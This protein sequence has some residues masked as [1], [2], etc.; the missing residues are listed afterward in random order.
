MNNYPHPAISREDWPF[1]AISMDASVKISIEDRVSVA[2][3]ILATL[4][5]KS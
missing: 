2:M 3:T 1:L 4:P 5:Q